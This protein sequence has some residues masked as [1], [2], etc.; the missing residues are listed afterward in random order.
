MTYR[1][2]MLEERVLTA[3]SPKATVH[4]RLMVVLG[5]FAHIVLLLIVQ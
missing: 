4:V 1:V 3:L 5:S 2:W